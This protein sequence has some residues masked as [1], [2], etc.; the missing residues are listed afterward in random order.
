MYSLFFKFTSGKP[1]IRK[2]EE[3]R[4]PVWTRVIQKPNNKDPRTIALEK[5]KVYSQLKSKK[6]KDSVLEKAHQILTHSIRNWVAG[7]LY[8]TLDHGKLLSQI[9]SNSHSTFLKKGV[10]GLI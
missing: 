5:E 9:E 4:L 1:E 10:K 7:L 3:G 8:I 6:H 2:V